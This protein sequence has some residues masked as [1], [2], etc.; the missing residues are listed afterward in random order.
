MV[1]LVLP[2]IAFA[3]FL[4]GCQTDQLTIESPDKAIRVEIARTA[5]GEAHYTVHYKGQTVIAPSAF[6]LELAGVPSLAEDLQLLEVERRGHDD[7]WQRPWG[8]R[9]TVHDHYNELVLHLASGDGSVK[10]DLIVRAYNDGIALRYALPEQAGLGAFEL[11]A[12]ETEF[13]FTADHSI[14]AAHYGGF[15]SHQESE[16]NRMSLSDPKLTEITALPMLVE[17]SESCWVALTEANLTDWAGMYL[18]Y[19]PS[20]PNGHWDGS[21]R[22]YGLK[23]AL[24]PLPDSPEVLVRSEAPRVSPWR[25][26]MIGDSAVS[27]TGSD[28]IANLNEP[29]AIDTSWIQSGKCAWDWWWCGKYDPSV[30]FELRSDTRT[31]KHFIDLAAEMDWDYQLVDWHWYGPPFES[32]DQP[33]PDSDITTCNPDIDIPELVRYAAERGVR[34]WLWLEWH[35]AD[36]QMDEAFALYEQWGIAGVKVD[37]MQRDDQEMVNFYHRL[38]KTAAEHKL[39]VNFHGAYKPTGFSRTYPNLITREGVMGNEY[40]K[41]SRRITAEHKVTIP[42]TRG[43][44]GEMDFTPGAWLHVTPEDFR[45]AETDDSAPATMTMGTRCNEMAMLVVYESA[46]A[47]LCDSPYNYRNSP[48]GTEFLKMVPTTWD[49]T[50][51][52]L[53]VVGDYICIARRSGDDWYVGTMTDENARSLSI[54]LSFLGK[55][56]YEASIWEDTQATLTDPSLLGKRTRTVTRDKVEIVKLAPGGGQVMVLTPKR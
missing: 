24:S 27:L 47:V 54:P 33:H 1:K 2:I 29:V 26:I 31:M 11:V 55:G 56:E 10:M 14:W 8:K 30:D 51:P 19:N 52:L 35:H 12:D 39:M 17:V 7:T 37:F 28:L 45:T 15:A 41:W 53:G 23:A 49:E 34:L 13:N 32:G 44:P 18:Q 6:G 3:L 21:Y 5:E 25:V 46:L 20:S 38:V 9:S 43:L 36:R 42:F 22:P 50:V 48:E 16:F 40:N 4:S